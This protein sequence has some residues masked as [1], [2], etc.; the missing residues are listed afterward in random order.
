MGS[1]ASSSPIHFGARM[2]KPS[3]F[4]S[5]YVGTLPCAL[6]LYYLLVA[7]VRGSNSVVVV[8]IYRA[9][10]VSTTTPLL[11]SSTY[12]VRNIRPSPRWVG[13]L[14]QG[15]GFEV[16]EMAEEAMRLI[17]LTLCTAKSP[18]KGN[19]VDRE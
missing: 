16:F 9:T 7:V 5:T 18:P 11:F 1:V 14:P 4:E 3:I 13:L 2:D 17:S 10:G 15:E 6:T 12:Y 8:A 19:L